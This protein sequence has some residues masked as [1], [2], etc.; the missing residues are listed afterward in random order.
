MGVHG[1]ESLIKAKIPNGFK[2]VSITQEIDEF[3]RY[4]A[5]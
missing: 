5:I 1:L 4:K 2:N 3:K